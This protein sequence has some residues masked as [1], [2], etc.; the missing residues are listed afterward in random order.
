ML[1]K[2]KDA[3]LIVDD[4]EELAQT[5]RTI[6]ETEGYLVDL[7][8]D[9]TS[10]LEK[11]ITHPFDAVILDLKLPDIDGTQLIQR[12]LQTNPY[13]IILMMTG[14]PD[15]RNTMDALN[16]GAHGYITKPVEAD[17]VL[18]ILRDK[19]QKQKETR[20]LTQEKMGEF[21]RLRLEKMRKMTD[22]KGPQ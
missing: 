3:V 22:E 5:L 2:E 7:A 19:L 11:G 18:E 1:A 13:A 16:F 20:I 10:A 17:Y 21:I 4:C 8:F 12:F 14:F 9:G 6:L 15:Q